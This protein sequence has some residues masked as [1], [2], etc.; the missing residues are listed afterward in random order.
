MYE[1]KDNEKVTPTI[2]YTS[3]NIIR[4]DLISMEIVRVNIWLRANSAPKYVHLLNAQMISLTGNGK[5]IKA[6]E[7][8][9]PVHTIIA[10]HTAPNQAFE[11][12]YQENEANRQMV[13]VKA[14]AQSMLN[15]S[16]KNRI[17]T[18]TELGTTLEVG[19]TKWYSLYDVTIATP[20]IPNMHLT[21]PMILLR[22][23]HF[24]FIPL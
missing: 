11:L 10:Y 3:D 19:R 21:A 9:V 17:S 5:I 4:G 8:F 14:V 23:E 7:I 24:A 12:D 18:Q 1:L 22:P 20:N 15:I 6:D 16:G 2:F 13:A